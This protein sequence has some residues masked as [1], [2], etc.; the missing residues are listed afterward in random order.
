MSWILV[1]FALF[2]SGRSTEIDASA[3]FASREACEMAA[4]QVR[5]ALSDYY[6]ERLMTVCVWSGEAP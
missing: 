5:K 1:M 6:E 2:G 3:K 4:M